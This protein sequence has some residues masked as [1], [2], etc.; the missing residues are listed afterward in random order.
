MKNPFELFETN[1]DLEQKGVWQDFGGFRVLLAHSG[2]ANTEYL[3]VL[4]A[5]T[6]KL[7]Y[8]TLDVAEA[9]DL[10]TIYMTTFCKAIIKGHQVKEDEDSDWTDGVYIRDDE[11]VK[12]ADYTNDSMAK[13]LEQLPQYY[14]KLQEWA[15]NYRMY[16]DNLDEKRVKN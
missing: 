5:E 4:G 10:K 1:E 2:G 14:L 16:Q 13:M 8:A 15:S 3:K 9:D 11:G 12:L 7:G 6:K